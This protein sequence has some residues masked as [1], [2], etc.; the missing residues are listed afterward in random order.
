MRYGRI[1]AVRRK[2]DNL[3]RFSHAKWIRCSSFV[4]GATPECLE[5][6]T[7]L[8]GQQRLLAVVARLARGHDVA[9]HA[10]S[11]AAERHEVIHGER[12]HADG[13]AAVI[14]EP[15]G[16]ASLPP[17]ARAQLARL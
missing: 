1:P 13:A 8:D 7:P 9:A 10:A 16:D 11:A 2:I 15:V 4:V 17:S 12:F 5:I 14:A 3:Q 6:L